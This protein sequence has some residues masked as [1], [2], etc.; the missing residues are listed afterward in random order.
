VRVVLLHGLTNSSRAFDRLTPL[1]DGFKVTAIDLP[2]HGCKADDP[3]LRSVEAIADAVIPEIAEIAGSAILLGHSL[4]GCT[5]TAIAERRPDLVTHLIVVNSPPTLAC[6]RVAGR[7]GEKALR[8]PLLGPLLWAM[9][10]RRTVRDGLRTAFAPGYDV[11]EVFVDDFRRLSCRTFVDGTNAV[12]AYIA[13][14]SLYERVESLSVPTTIVFGE[15]D[16]RIDP[17]CLAGYAS[18]KA[19]VV[20]I[21][22]AGHT[23]AWETPEHVAAVVRGV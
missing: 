3:G 8:T 10:T 20:K 13:D 21:A 22:E 23:P 11:P 4:G 17:A 12:D 6:R 7:G 2:G 1:L 19:D 9:M 18:R 14:G 5:A 15:L 16:Q